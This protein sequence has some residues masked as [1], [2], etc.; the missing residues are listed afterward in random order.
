MERAPGE[1]TA[2]SLSALF[3]GIPAPIAAAAID[4]YRALSLYAADPVMPREGFER[5][6]TAMRAGG[7]LSHDVA[8]EDCMDNSL[9]EEA[10]ASKA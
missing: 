7:I 10:A 3:P 6:H 1:E 9:A 4:R 2:Q 5:L 8:F